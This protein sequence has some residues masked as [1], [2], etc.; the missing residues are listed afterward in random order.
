MP[1]ITGIDFDN[2]HFVRIEQVARKIQQIYLSTIREAVQIGTAVSISDTSKPFT[3]D[4]YPQTKARAEKLLNAHYTAISTILNQATKDEWLAAIE[5]KDEI[6]KQFAIEKLNEE[7]KALRANR[8]LEALQAFQTRK[9]NGIGLSDRIWN[10]TQAYKQELEMGL[11]LGIGDGRSASE[12]S[13]DL[14]SYLTEPDRLFRRVRDKHGNLQ[15][16]KNAKAYSPWDG[17]YRSS[18]KNA[19]RLTRTEINIAYRASDYEKNQQLDFVVGF[20]VVRSNNPYPCPVCNALKG[21]Y[22]KSFKFVGWHPQCRCHVEDILATQDEF[23]AHQTK[24]LNG[25]R[26][27]VLKSANEVKGLPK[28]FTNWIDDNIERIAVAKERGTLPYFLKDNSLH[29]F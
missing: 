19:M 20:E 6:A 23:L 17:T 27:S 29:S 28:G 25:D 9:D 1:K 10:L 5:K 16:S 21:K 2:A 11:D 12:L 3:F 18:Y 24:L 22:P 15:L 7:Q 26:N 4:N 14:R 8:N 13:R